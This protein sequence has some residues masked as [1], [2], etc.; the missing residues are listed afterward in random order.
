M[1]ITANAIQTIAPNNNVFF[2]DTSVKGSC[3]IV[4]RDNSGLIT[5]RGI[6]NQCRARFKVTFNSNVALSEGTTV[7]PISLALAINGEAIGPATMISTPAAVGEYN[8]ISSSIFINV[9][10]GCCYTI[11][12]KNLTTVG[13]ID[14][15]NANLLIERVA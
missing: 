15:Q 7:G 2:T 12:V 3:S 13:D 10:N 6:T 11:S 1:E 4:H 14:M 8:N 5:L 9:P